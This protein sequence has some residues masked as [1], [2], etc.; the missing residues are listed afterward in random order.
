MSDTASLVTPL[1]PDG[2]VPKSGTYVPGGRGLPTGQ[3]PPLSEMRYVPLKS[4]LPPY[5]HRRLCRPPSGSSST[6]CTSPAQV[7]DR[8][9]NA[10]CSIVR[11]EAG[12]VSVELDSKGGNVPGKLPPP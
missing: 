2:Q 12:S 9:T 7:C 6:T 3:G 5:W 10:T 1:V 8:L 11:A 4:E